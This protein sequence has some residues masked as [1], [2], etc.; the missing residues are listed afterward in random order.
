[1]C[2]VNFGIIP[3]IPFVCIFR[4]L[5]ICPITCTSWFYT[6]YFR[7]STNLIKQISRR[8]QE[9]FQEKSRTCLPCFGLLRTFLFGW[10]E[11]K[12]NTHNMG[13]SALRSRIVIWGSVISSHT[14]VRGRA[15]AE[16]GFWCIWN[17]KKNTYDGDKF[18]TCILTI[19]N[20][21]LSIFLWL[22]TNAVDL[23]HLTQKISRRTN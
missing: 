13:I 10:E 9:G 5:V 2:M 6:S 12:W 4:Q 23:R 14:G 21:Y 17:L 20:E 7:V 16:N 19:N 18:R 11:L 3:W 1:M 8:F 15:P 22:E